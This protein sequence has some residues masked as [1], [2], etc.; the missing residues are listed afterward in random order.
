MIVLDKM[1]EDWV[2]MFKIVQIQIR[3]IL[4]NVLSIPY[5]QTAFWKL[6]YFTNT[7]HASH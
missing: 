5:S 3:K 1:S 2:G 6:N 7:A 4:E